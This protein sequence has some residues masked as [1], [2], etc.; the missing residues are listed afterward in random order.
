MNSTTRSR[1]QANLDYHLSV[2][3]HYASEAAEE[4]SESEK[5]PR[6]TRVEAEAERPPTPEEYVAKLHADAAKDLQQLLDAVPAQPAIITARQTHP[7][8]GMRVPRLH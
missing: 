4:G 8:R 6:A 1:L 5:D 3:K 7:T 2:A